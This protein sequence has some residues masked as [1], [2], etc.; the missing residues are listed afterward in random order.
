MSSTSPTRNPATGTVTAS[1]PVRSVVLPGLRLSGDVDAGAE[2]G[3]R[4]EHDDVGVAPAEGDG[5]GRR[6]VAGVVE[7][8]PPRAEGEQDAADG[9]HDQPG[10]DALRPDL[11]DA[12]ARREDRLAEHDDR[13]QAVALLDVLGVE[14]AGVACP[15]ARVGPQRHEQLADGEHEER[16]GP[17]TPAG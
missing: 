7:V 14:Q 6:E 10:G 11:A 12:D 8:Q 15:C 2:G 5:A 13:E 16:A 9:D 1:D 3:E 17:T 4:G